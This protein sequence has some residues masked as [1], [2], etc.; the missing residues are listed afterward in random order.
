MK[1]FFISILI[2]I[3]ALTVSITTVGCA[4]TQILSDL[5]HV[6]VY[7]N[8]V[9]VNCSA[10][11]PSNG[12]LYT[13]YGD[14][15]ALVGIGTCTDTEIVISAYHLGKPVIAINSFSDNKL[16]T[17]IEIPHTVKTI[18][19]SAFSG[20]TKLQKVIFSKNSALTEIGINAFKYCFSLTQIELP[21]SLT[22]IQNGAFLGCSGL[23]E[24]FIPISVTTVRNSIFEGCTNLTKIYCQ[25]N[26]KPNGWDNN[27]MSY[28]PAT[29]YWNSER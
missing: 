9:C 16:V 3:F 10:K 17:S 26:S 27:W 4:G 5:Y 21:N 19:A 28:C 1:K 6:C 12:L 15:Y 7:D 2:V 20:C 18:F 13:E 25:A 29:V 22:T 14:G 23:E 24:I 8:D 11:R